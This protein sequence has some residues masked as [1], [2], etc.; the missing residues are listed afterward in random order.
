MCLDCSSAGPLVSLACLTHTRVQH[1]EGRGPRS[2]TYIEREREVVLM[3]SGFRSLTESN[4]AKAMSV[5]YLCPENF[6]QETV[7]VD[8]IAGQIDK[9]QYVLDSHH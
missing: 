4:P 1:T 6:S 2:S 9:Q 7:Y 8:L 3:L 5:C